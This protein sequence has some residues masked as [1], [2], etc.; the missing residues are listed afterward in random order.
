M[1]TDR[2]AD[3][4]SRCR[5]TT[6]RQQRTGT[7]HPTFRLSRP[8]LV[9]V[10]VCLCLCLCLPHLRQ[11]SLPPYSLLHTTLITPTL[12]KLSIPPP[13]YC[14]AAQ[15]PKR[16]EMT[17]HSMDGRPSNQRPVVDAKFPQIRNRALSMRAPEEPSSIRVMSEAMPIG[18]IVDIWPVGRPYYKSQ[19]ASSRPYF[20]ATFTTATHPQPLLPCT[21]TTIHPRWPVCEIL[22]ACIQSRGRQVV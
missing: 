13:T 21:H 16:D 9:C 4:R 5:R 8:C 17:N 22:R 20:S 19:I 11:S 6:N 3:H 12:Y 14:A 18:A 7:G 2:P 1:L 15:H 10:C